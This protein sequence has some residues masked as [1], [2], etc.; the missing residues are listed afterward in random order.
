MHFKILFI[1]SHGSKVS[2]LMFSTV[3]PTM[4]VE[5]ADQ[6]SGGVGRKEDGKIVSLEARESERKFEYR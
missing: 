4:E 1:G 3:P 2:F 6:H 5:H